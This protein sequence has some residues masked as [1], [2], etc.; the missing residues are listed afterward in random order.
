MTAARHLRRYPSARPST[1]STLE[2]K[3]AMTARLN[4][5]NAAA[6]RAKQGL[7]YYAFK[8]KELASQAARL[9]M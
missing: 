3:D 7:G 2:R 8:L 9:V 1:I 4:R 5:E 6:R